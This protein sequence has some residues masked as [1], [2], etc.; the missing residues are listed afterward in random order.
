MSVYDTM[1]WAKAQVTG[2]VGRKAVLMALAERT[3]EQPVCWPS[4]A[5]LAAE[6]EQSVRTVRRC[7]ADLEAAGLIVSKRCYTLPD[8]TSLPR[9]KARN[10]YTLLVDQA[11]SLTSSDPGPSGQGC[12]LLVGG[13]SGQ[14]VTLVPRP[15]GQTE[16]TKR[17]NGADQADTVVA[18][19]VPVLELPSSER[20]RDLSALGPDY[21]PV[22]PSEHSRSIRSEAMRRARSELAAKGVPVSHGRGGRAS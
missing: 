2:S 19:E 17:P 13:P 14:I 21:T 18:A 8:G 4:Q 7:L 10:E 22:P 20:S 12:G 5:L 6:T 9:G 3:G 15:S 16:T 11:D 1:A